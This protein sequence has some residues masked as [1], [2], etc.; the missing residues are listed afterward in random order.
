MSVDGFRAAMRDALRQA[1]SFALDPG[2]V[3]D[4]HSAAFGRDLVKRDQPTEAE[5]QFLRAA[6]HGLAAIARSDRDPSLNATTGHVAE[7]ITETLLADSGWTIVEQQ[8][9][10]VSAGHGIDLGALSPDMESLFVIEVK[11]SLSAARWP[12]LTRRDIT[13]FSPAWLD[14][15]DQPGMNSLGVGATD[16]YGLVVT[17]QFGLGLW[18]AAATADFLS[19]TPIHVLDQLDDVS[20]LTQEPD[21]TQVC[22]HAPP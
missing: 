7:S 9:G 2:V 3:A 4:H 20:W 18:R 10:D 6:T 1:T 13:Q 15:P 12:Q 21:T 8:P 14:K 16:V 22:D 19:V 5:R 17:I 11:G